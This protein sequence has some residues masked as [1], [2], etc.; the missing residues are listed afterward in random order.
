MNPGSGTLASSFGLVEHQIIRHFRPHRLAPAQQIL[1][2]RQR[3]MDVLG[4]E[5][6]HQAAE[7]EVGH[8]EAGRLA[9]DEQAGNAKVVQ[10]RGHRKAGR[11][12]RE[13]KVEQDEVGLTIVDRDHGAVGILRH[14]DHPVAR[15]VL[16]QI[17]QA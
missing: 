17:F 5:R 16:D 12:V 3:A 10:A 7:R 1:G 4:R 15:I 11:P 14:A 13:M 9:A 6:L 8:G 2:R